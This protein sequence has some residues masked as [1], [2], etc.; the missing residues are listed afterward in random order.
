MSHIYIYIYVSYIYIYPPPPSARRG[1]ARLW[2]LRLRLL[3]PLKIAPRRGLAWP[4]LWRASACL[5]GAQPALGLPQ[6]RGVVRTPCPPPLHTF[7][8]TVY[9]MFLSSVLEWS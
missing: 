9:F 2:P 3:C 4:G 8:G 7:F 6:T 1:V 5:R